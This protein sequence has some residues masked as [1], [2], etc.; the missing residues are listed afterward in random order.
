MSGFRFLNLHGVHTDSCYVFGSVHGFVKP[1]E[2]RG[3]MAADGKPN[4]IDLWFWIYWLQFP[5]PID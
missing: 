4:D 2:H 1:R 3:F 5:F